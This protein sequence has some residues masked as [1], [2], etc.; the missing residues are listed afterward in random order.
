MK[1][2]PFILLLVSFSLV[3]CGTLSNT[4]SVS[5]EQQ[6][7]DDDKTAVALALLQAEVDA[8]KARSKK[9]AKA[10][11][12]AKEAKSLAK[13][14]DESQK[15]KV[16]ADEKAEE[17]RPLVKAAWGVNTPAVIRAETTGPYHIYE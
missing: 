9:Q 16:L 1:L 10:L 4:L 5:E 6:S 14:K 17:L 15:A 12:K 7:S 2:L 3:G 11:A 8:L 13:A